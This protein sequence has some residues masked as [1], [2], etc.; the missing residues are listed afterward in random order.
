MGHLKLTT[1]IFVI[2]TR[3]R[4]TGGMATMFNNANSLAQE[5][6]M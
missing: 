6:I 4:K 5:Y 3:G 1:H 2:E